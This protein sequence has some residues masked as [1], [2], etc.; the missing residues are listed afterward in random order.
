MKT[1]KLMIAID[2]M[3][4]FL[5]EG[6]CSYTTLGIPKGGKI[7]RWWVSLETNSLHIVIEDPEQG[8]PTRVRHSVP[9]LRLDNDGQ[10]WD[11]DHWNEPSNLMRL[12]ITT[13]AKKEL[14]NEGDD[15]D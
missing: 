3:E 2:E 7:L 9:P 15:H 11:D 1:S 12:A 5:T 4:K 14:P 13:M 6:N 8:I 10:G